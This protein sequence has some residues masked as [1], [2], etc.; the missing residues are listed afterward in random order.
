MLRVVAG[1][2]VCVLD[3]CFVP[4]EVKIRAS[5]SLGLELWM[6]VRHDEAGNQP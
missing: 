4:T 6:F 2:Y 5:D 3:A 1:T